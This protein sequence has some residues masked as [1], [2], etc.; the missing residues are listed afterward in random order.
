[1]SH[2]SLR[3]TARKQAGVT[4]H[5]LAKLTGIPAPT[6]SLWERD[7]ANLPPARVEQ[8]ATILFQRISKGLVF[9]SA[10]DLLTK[11]LPTNKATETLQI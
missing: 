8:I 7:L 4:Q 2:E 3:S 11:L 1:M 10:H 6:I 9:G 5:A